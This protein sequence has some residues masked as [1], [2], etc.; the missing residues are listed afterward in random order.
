[1][2]KATE[3]KEALQRAGISQIHA[4]SML[5]VTFEHLNRVLNGHRQ[6]RRLLQKVLALSQEV[7]E[8]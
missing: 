8:K 6:S 5:G 3:A 1:M 4:A 2:S 7:H